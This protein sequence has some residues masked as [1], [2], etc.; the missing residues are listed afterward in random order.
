MARLGKLRAIWIRLGAV[1]GLK[2]FDS[3]IADELECHLQMEIDENL[4]AGMSAAEA[5]RQALLRHGGLAQA[6]QA[7]RERQGLPALEELGQDLRFGMRMLAKSPAFAVVAVLTLGLGIGANTA[8][9][10][11][12]NAVLL[13]P[14]PYPH[15]DELVTVHASKANFNE[16]SISYLNFRDW[17]R[18]N[19]TLDALAIS[20][21]TGFILTGAGAAEEVRGELVSSDFFP[22]LG[23]KPAMGRLFAMHEDEIGRAPLAIVSA[24]FWA[25]KLGS[26]P[27]VL[28]KSLTLDG[29]DYTIVG[30]VP[31]SFNLAINQFRASDIYLPMGQFQNP[32]LND[33]AAGLGI[34]GIARLKPG[35]TLEQAQADMEAVSRRLSMA[36]PLEDQGI[37]AKLVPF[38]ESMVR[39]V[40]PL[41]LVLMAAVGFV[42]L[43][44]CVNV[45]NLLLARSNVRAQEFAVR[46][47]LGAGRIRLVRQLLTESVMLS[48]MGG[49]LGLLL[50]ALGT[51]AM[52]KL[53]PE[54]LPR[55][56]EIHIDLPVLCFTIGV[57]LASG[58]LFGLAPARKLF[59]QN[60]QDVLKAGGRSLSGAGHR[61]QDGLV[62]FQMA[63]A[64]VLLIGAGLMIRSLVNLSNIDP[65]FHPQGVLT[66]GLEGPSSLKAAGPEAQRAYLRAAQEKLGNTPG[67]A[68]ASLSWAALP[69]MGDDEQSFWL[70]G[71]AKPANENTMRFAIRYIVGPEYL[72]VM[73][74]PLLKGRFL[75]STDDEHGPRV[76]VV[77]DLFVKKFFGDADPIGKRIHLEQFD[78]P[79]TV[80]GV[81]GHVNQW[82]L[83]S[84]AANPLRA[85]TY[86]SLLQLPEIQL[87]LA[88]MGM[89]AVVR[90]RSG[91]VPSFKAIES[92]VTQMNHEQAVYN[93][94]SMEQVIADTLAT[95]RFS[96]I[97][98][99]VFAGTAL[100]LASIGMYGVIS[101]LV[102]QRAREIGIRMALGA[103]RGAVLRWV[104]RRGTRLALI[105][106]AAGLVGAMALTEW[107]ASAAILF[108][109]K[110][111]DPWTL[112]GVTALMMGVALAACYLPA[113]RA[114]RIEPMAALRAD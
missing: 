80:I 51:R 103:D 82:G 55:A 8:L 16:G 33:R 99:A 81:V 93:P 63:S 102:G 46:S 2:Q 111:Y 61:M 60:V 12:V 76:V 43:I 11:V 21:G 40:R 24:G 50:A 110:P 17:Q 30:V 62:I 52:L 73:G 49:A 72:R 90:S 42:L 34:H 86:Q 71:E 91:A 54:D 95:R 108:G 6:Q 89:D 18:D 29:R 66:F 37:V 98:L 23:V 112:S 22:V 68:A 41:L 57:S 15:A 100:V 74:I 79:A 78:E 104:L 83:G 45:A 64:L 67:I 70:E 107:M 9:F 19:K 87:G 88:V 7:Y 69:M 25:R 96:M 85:E 20:R 58:I 31:A 48:A 38:R 59:K 92:S 44:A 36:Y 84:D 35:V 14:L 77:D 105:G 97:L 101:Y 13:N 47:A 32:A 26:R 28:G 106:A 5:R 65:G 113:R 39:D 3:G 114:T 4:R 109:V 53:I 1:F 75:E 56:A 94:Y 27:D 10:S